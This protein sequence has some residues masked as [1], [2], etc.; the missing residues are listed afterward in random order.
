VPNTGHFVMI[1][2]PDH[3]TATLDHFLTIHAPGQPV[4]FR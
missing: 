1:D 3:F 2:D 4:A